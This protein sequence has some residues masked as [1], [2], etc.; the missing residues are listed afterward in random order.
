MKRLFINSILISAIVIAG[1]NVTSHT[2]KS[3]GVDFSNYKTFSWAG[4]G[5]AK[6]TDRADNDIIDNNIKN[7]V[8]QELI[9][10]GWT[11]VDNNPDVLVDYTVAVKRGAKRE[12]EPVYSYPYTQYSY[13]DAGGFSAYGILQL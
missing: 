10:K 11:E 6:K 12:S 8:S 2:E 13:M 9:K 1:C 3:A 5:D 4:T 7:S